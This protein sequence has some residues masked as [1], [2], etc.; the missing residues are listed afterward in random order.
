MSVRRS[1]LSPALMVILALVVLVQ[2]TVLFLLLMVPPEQDPVLG[3]LR[4]S[5]LVT[6]VVEMCL[7]AA[8]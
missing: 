7:P 4:Q 5:R 6:R 3:A 2:S 8:A 1:G